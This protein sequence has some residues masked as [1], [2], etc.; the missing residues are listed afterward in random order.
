MGMSLV[1]SVACLLPDSNRQDMPESK[2]VCVSCVK[3]HRRPRH[4]DSRA[5]I[6]AETYAMRV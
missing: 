3:P 5:F 1:W 4:E 2:V 6:E